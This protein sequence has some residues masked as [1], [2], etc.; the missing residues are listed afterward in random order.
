MATALQVPLLLT[1]LINNVMWFVAGIFV[2]IWLYLLQV[3]KELLGHPFREPAPRRD[4]DP[5][6]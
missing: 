2:L 5:A 4:G 6:A 1:G 3:R